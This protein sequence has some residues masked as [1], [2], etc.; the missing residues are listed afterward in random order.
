MAFPT[1]IVAVGGVVEDEHGNI[2]LVK[3]HDGGWVFPGGQVEVGENLPDALRRE[4][5]EESD[6]DVA[7]GHLIGMYSN[8]GIHK[9]YDG[10]TDVPTKLMVDFVCEPVG[11]ALSASEET[12]EGRWV[13][14]DA[15][16]DFI[17]APAIRNH[18]QA[19]LDFDGTA[20]YMEYVTKP[21]F[22]IRHRARI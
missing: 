12:T 17:T 20:A 6:I 10:I 19:Y 9:W 4:I 3:T 15:V 16:L 22:E 2:L 1:H 8:T 21:A 13:P 7:V 18:F 5:K 14:N 11:G